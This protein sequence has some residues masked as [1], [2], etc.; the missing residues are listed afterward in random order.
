MLLF[1]YY[2]NDLQQHVPKLLTEVARI[3]RFL[4][5]L[6]CGERL[7][8]LIDHT[9]LQALVRLRAIPRTAV[10]GAQLFYDLYII[11]KTVLHMIPSRSFALRRFLL[12]RQSFQ[13]L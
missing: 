4:Q 8:S 13:R 2:Q 6:D 10:R 1:V 11:F 12:R 5:N 9:R 7:R 3:T